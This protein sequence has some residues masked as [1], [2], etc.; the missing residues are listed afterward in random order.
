MASSTTILSI[1]PLA[2]RSSKVAQRRSACPSF[3]ESTEASY[4]F[5]GLEETDQ[6]QLFGME[7]PIQLTLQDDGRSSAMITGGAVFFD[8]TPY[9]ISV[10]LPEAEDAR[11]FSP[12]A[13]WCE[14]ADWDSESCRLSLPVNFQ[15]D[16]GD[17]EFCWEWQGMDGVWHS[18]SMR[19]QVYS[20]K[21]NIQTHFNWMIRDVTERFDWLRMDLLRQTTWGWNRDEGLDGSQ[22]TWLLI[23]QEVHSEMSEGFRK[24]IKQH[25][26]RLLPKEKMLRADQLRRVSARFE[27][28]VAEGICRNPQ[29]CFHVQQQTLNADTPENRYIKYVLIHTLATLHDLINRLEPVARISDVFKE[30]L[31][32]WADEW[33]QLSQHRFWKSIGAFHGLRRESL[34]LS[35]DSLYAGIRLSWYWLQ[36][37]LIFIDQYLRGGIQNAAQLYEIWCFVKIDAVLKSQ[38]WTCSGDEEILFDRMDDDWENEEPRAGTITL[39]YAKPAF[40]S[41][42]L[43]LL[44]QPTARSSPNKKNTFEG[45][46][47]IPITQRPDIVLRLHRNDLPHKPTYTWIFDA[48][49]RINGNNA[50]DEA[51]NQMHRYRDAILWV[52]NMLGKKEVHFTRESIGGFILYPGNEKNQGSFPQIASIEKTNIGAFPLLPQ[53]TNLLPEKLSDHISRLLDISSDY[54]GVMEDERHFYQSVPEVKKPSLGIIGVVAVRRYMDSTRYWKTCRLYRL[55]TNTKQTFEVPPEKWDYIAPQKGGHGHYGL[56]PILERSIHTRSELLNIY[57]RQGIYIEAKPK[58]AQ[59]T[60]WLFCLGEPISAP[61]DL[62]R[63][64]RGR[65]VKIIKRTG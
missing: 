54:D 64:Q 62:N 41:V 40:D 60:Y 26:R 59:S 65:I 2:V 5:A 53:K 57:K 48:K 23:F 28:R 9:M 36:Q 63:L 10:Y 15:N 51:V 44:F 3:I 55:P 12:L 56:F 25:R 24:I 52:N 47:S 50:P 33:E 34:I 17:F 42:K 35:Q 14:S 11:I 16:L 46:V 7:N 18:G 1:G 43:E 4:S 21:L 8:Q 29:T 45:M 13:S 30:R 6:L 61:P 37:G 38:G 32:D 27:E 39:S 22:K 49:Y 31:Q 19:A 20:F 58:Y